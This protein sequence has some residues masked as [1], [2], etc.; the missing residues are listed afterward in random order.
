MEQKEIYALLAKAQSEFDPV[1]FDKKGVYGKYASLTATLAAVK[2]ALNAQGITIHHI[3]GDGGSSTAVKCVLACASGTIESGWCDFGSKNLD[4]Q[5]AGAAITYAKRYT[6]AGLCGV[7]GEEDDDAE[8]IVGYSIN[9]RKPAK[10]Q[11]TEEAKAQREADEAAK[12]ELE[13]KKEK[14]KADLKTAMTV[15]F[16]AKPGPGPAVEKLIA[17]VNT[18]FK[19]EFFPIVGYKGK[20]L[21]VAHR[22]LWENKNADYDNKSIADIHPDYEYDFEMGLKRKEVKNG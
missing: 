4:A 12:A 3:V 9:E 21:D 10:K 19:D 20:P 16:K 17:R 1:I 15:L 13:A 22:A 5:K 14:L 11:E 6:L 18:F 8:S 2:P 7:A